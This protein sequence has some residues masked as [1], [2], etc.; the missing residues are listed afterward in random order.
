MIKPAV[1]SD[2]IYAQMRR[3]YKAFKITDTIWRY[4]ESL[5]LYTEKK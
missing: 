5:S 3:I 4:M 1:A 2:S